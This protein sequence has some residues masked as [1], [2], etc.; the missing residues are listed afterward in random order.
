MSTILKVAFAGVALLSAGAATAA[1]VIDQ[2]QASSTDTKGV[3]F[4]AA[5]GG[6]A[7]SYTQSFKQTASTISGIGI[8]LDTGGRLSFSE[9]S[10]WSNAALFDGMT[11]IAFSNS[12]SLDSAT[13]WLDFGWAPV[14]ITPGATYTLK[15]KF[16]GGSSAPQYTVN[17]SDLDPY[18]NGRMTDFFYGSD[19]ITGDETV[20]SD[21]Y[22]ANGRYDLTF[23]TFAVAPSAVPEPATWAMLVG[24]MMIAGAAL[25]RKRM[26]L[27]A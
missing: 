10:E 22:T 24:G 18:A 1:T 26:L 4:L 2:L 17:A 21:F 11:Q 7:A 25:R 8:N 20:I 19:P 3:F 5:P 14:T 27:A 9:P 13:G 23:R 15:V 12:G 16:F 6:S